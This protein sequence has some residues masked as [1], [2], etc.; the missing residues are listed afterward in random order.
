MATVN[1]FAVQPPSAGLYPAS[2]QWSPQVKT[3]KEGTSLVDALNVPRDWWLAHN[4]PVPKP[5]FEQA[6]LNP[7]QIPN[8][9]VQALVSGAKGV[10]NTANDFGN[11]PNWSPMELGMMLATFAGPKAATANL[12]AL[13]AAKAMEGAGH[14]ADAIWKETGW[15]RGADGKW[16]FEIPDNQ[17][18][19]TPAY[20]TA[21]KGERKTVT[22]PLGEGMAHDKAYAAYPDMPDIKYVADIGGGNSGAYGLSEA[23]KGDRRPFVPTIAAEGPL[24]ESLTSTT[25]HEMQ[26]HI[27]GSEGFSRGGS[28]MDF[29]QQKQAELARDA[30][31]WRRELDAKRKQMPNADLSAI[32]NAVVEDYHQMGAMDWLPSRQARDIAANRSGNPDAQLQE[33]VDFY[34]LNR[35]VTPDTGQQLYHRLSGEV[36]ARNVQKRM[37][38]TPEQRRQTPPWATEDVP[39]NQQIVRF[40]Q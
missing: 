36:E 11:M 35:K 19:A 14:A 18:T 26:H 15:G 40:G 21:V 3:L 20:W 31:A 25:L 4:L 9:L 27:Q 17:A 34:G 23:P 33:I 24:P 28:P 30:L 6:D 8:Q 13:E 16:R 38:M 10:V 39:R 7:S 1:P 32:E 22:M 12:P 5:P 37:D 29:V 2:P